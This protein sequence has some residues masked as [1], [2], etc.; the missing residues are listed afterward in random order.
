MI[1]LPISDPMLQLTV[2]AVGVLLVHLLFQRLSIPA[3]VGLLVIGMLVGP[4][5]YELVPSEPVVGLL[6]TVGLVY[7]MFLAGIEID[8]EVVRH[9]K[10]EAIGFG[11]TT[12][13][14]SMV[15]AVGVGLVFA[16][17]WA[18]ALLIGAALSSHT[19]LG[20]PII[21]RQKLMHHRPIVA[22]I[23]GT[24]LTDTLALVMLVLVLQSAGGD[25]KGPDGYLPLVLLVALV[26]VGLLVLP[27]SSRWFFERPWAHRADKALAVLA[28]LFVL[29][30]AAEL[31]GTKNI[32]GAFLAGL[33]LNRSLKSQPPLLE[34]V[35]FAGQVLFIPFFFLS[36]GMRLELDVLLGGSEA[37]LEA[38]MLLLA[39]VFAK[40]AAAW[41]TGWWFGYRPTAR[42][43]MASLALPQAAATLAVAVTALQ[44]ELIDAT[45][46]DAIIIVIF[47]TCLVG[48]M[49]T[50]FAG[51][52]IAKDA[53]AEADVKDKQGGDSQVEPEEPAR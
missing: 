4:G 19:L 28:V 17:G 20:Y 13:I 46:V 24:L 34:H 53:E 11:L 48:P 37:W 33:C 29:S 49:I 51:R 1:E 6:G 39:I 44:A 45:T 42:I 26:A 9:H 36:T 40:F 50:R 32:L 47:V 23:G 7:I 30:M 25:T 8:L 2:L 35:R 16:D 12:F 14:L 41:A 10:A 52:R 27:R 18:G 3:L 31:I 5:G 38:A 21:K 22:T 15:S 43:V